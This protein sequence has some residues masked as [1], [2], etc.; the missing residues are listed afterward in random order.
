MRKISMV[1]LLVMIISSLVLPSANANSTDFAES[2]LDGSSDVLSITADRT[3]LVDQV[4]S[5]IQV[6]DLALKK[7][8]WS[9]KFPIIYDSQVLLNP[10]KI[11]VITA[12]N[13]KLKKV[14]LSTDGRVISEQAFSNIQL[15]GDAKVSW[16]PKAGQNKEAIAVALDGK[17]NLY[18]YPWNKPEVTL[19]YVVPED[20]AY[21]V[22]TV[23]NVKL[24]SGYAVLQI[25]GDNSS[26]DQDLYRVVNLLSKKKYTIPVKWNTSSQFA[27]EGKELVVTTSSQ[28]GHPLGLDTS[29]QHMIYARYDLA[30]GGKRLD[31]TRNFTSTESNWSAS[32]FNHRLTLIDSE[33][34]KL[35]VLDQKGNV[36]NDIPLIFSNKGL[37]GKLVGYYEDQ[38][39]MLAR[40]EGG[41]IELIETSMK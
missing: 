35:S 36:I 5:Q 41:H 28:I 6:L 2:L 19:S 8:V 34:N 31:V 7:I 11:V 4:N 40:G 32:Y 27:I 21:E 16:S 15:A 10:A 23:Q 9:K 18:Q 22:T 38:F 3:L 17:L 12:E 14:T 37:S 39:Y 29:A 13:N 1:M 33:Q 20:K 24:Q 25:N 30:T 26:Q